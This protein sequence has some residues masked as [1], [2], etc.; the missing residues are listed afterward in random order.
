MT[1]SITFNRRVSK[2]IIYILLILVVF[3]T[4]LPF[5]WMLSASI[6]TNMEV[7]QMDPF[8]LIPAEPQWSN[9]I[10]IWERI[11]LGIFIKNTIYY[12]HKNNQKIAAMPAV[13]INL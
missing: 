1:K 12:F 9:Y 6:K 5:I 7:F 3:I 8:V 10:D 13:F 2:I 11:P 4:V